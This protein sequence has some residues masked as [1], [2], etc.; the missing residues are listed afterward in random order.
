MCFYIQLSD[1]LR[2]FLENG[3]KIVKFFKMKEV[4]FYVVV[5]FIILKSYLIN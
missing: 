2:K 3:K 4:M 5:N 1:K